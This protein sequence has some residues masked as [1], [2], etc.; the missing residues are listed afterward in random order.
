MR[1]IRDTSRPSATPRL[2]GR[3]LRDFIDDVIR[4]VTLAAFFGA[5]LA[6]K[7]D[8]R[9]TVVAAIVLGMLA[10]T[11]LIA[12]S[13]SVFD[14]FAERVRKPGWMVAFFIIGLSLLVSSGIFFVAMTAVIK[15]LKT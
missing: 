10:F 12:T 11:M 1:A 15:A 7:L 8:D 6:G 3:F 5:A 4:L 9:T 13:V 14:Y 2:F